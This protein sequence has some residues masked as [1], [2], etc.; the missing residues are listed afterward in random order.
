M[1]QLAEAIDQ[2][3]TEK[4]AKDAAR[5]VDGAHMRAL[6]DSSA[7][8][9]FFT[10]LAVSLPVKPDWSI[11]TA[12]VDGK[13]IKY[14]PGFIAGLSPDHVH[15]VMIGHEPAHC[16][17][18]H[19]WRGRGMDCAICRNLAADL[20]V[21]W[22]NHEA[23]F[24]VTP[25]VVMPGRSPFKDCQAGDSFEQHYARLHARFHPPGGGDSGHQGGTF[26]SPG[27][28]EPAKDEATASAIEAEWLGKI[29]AAA[30]DVARK[31]AEG[32]LKGDLPGSLKRWIDG[33]LNPKVHWRERLRDFLTQSLRKHNENDWSRPSRRALAA[34]MYLPRHKGDELG[35]LAVVID[36]SGS[37]RQEEL[38]TFAAELGAIL[39][40]DPARLMLVY[41]DAEVNKMATWEPNDGP[42]ELEAVGGGGTDFR[43][44][45]D[46]ISQQETELAAAIYLT[47][48]HGDYPE[49]QPSYPVLWAMTTDVTPPW[50]RVVRIED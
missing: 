48:G 13:T 8:R 2:L 27:E 33:M 15:F 9:A 39:A 11:P 31:M 10:Q 1:P 49:Q 38:D 26:V 37:I 19:I 20:E 6:F 12:N 45:I 46:W 25:D 42:L 32:K 30:Q 41:A 5:L 44:A 18:G 40:C 24:A 28:F 34:D 14:N 16:H 7:A 3:K 21:N 23:G 47:D 50:G 35:Q 43:P 22:T 36:T 17:L 29:A 4:L